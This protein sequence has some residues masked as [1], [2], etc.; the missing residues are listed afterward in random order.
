MKNDLEGIR[1]EL[2]SLNIEIAK[3]VEKRLLL[4]EQILE[5][6]KE[7]GLPLFDEVRE[8]KMY[9]SL[10]AELSGSPVYQQVL[11]SMET[12]FKESFKHLKNIS[13]KGGSN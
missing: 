4:M 13:V 2:D 6:K 1:L 10:E 5:C 12:I 8:N 3:T 7:S 9:K 11:V